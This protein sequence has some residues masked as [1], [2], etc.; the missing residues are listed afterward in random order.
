MEGG[1]LVED[2]AV[3]RLSVEE[4]SAYAG[5]GLTSTSSRPMR[6][7]PTLPPTR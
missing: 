3:R 7:Y 2:G 1:L 6:A 5:E 4:A